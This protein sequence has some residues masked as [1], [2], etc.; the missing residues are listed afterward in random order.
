[1]LLGR[2]VERELF[3]QVVDDVRSGRSRA[4]VIRGEAGIGKTALL[5]E[6][7]GQCDRCSVVR[8]SGVQSEMELAY[9]ALHQVSAPFFNRRA[10]L[11]PPQREALETVFGLQPGAPPDQFLV[12]LA[13]L[14]LLSAAASDQPLVCLIDDAHWLDRASLQ[15]LAFVARR[16]AADSVAIVFA[17]RTPS[18]PPELDG[19]PVVELAG[20]SPRDAVALLGTVVPASI[21]PRARARVIAET[22]GNPLAILE[23]PQSRTPE[24]IAS[25]YLLATGNALAGELE[26]TFRE[27][28][29]DLPPDTRML[30]LVAAAEP[31]ADADV[32]ARAGRSLGI[33]P[34]A[35]AAAVRAGLCGP[36][37]GLQMRHPLVRSAVYRAAS[38]D[39][40]RRVHAALAEA[41]SARRSPIGRGTSCVPRARRSASP[42]RGQRRQN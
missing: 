19:L 9:A 4:L 6:F 36:A 40:L 18:S 24:E 22:R 17:V 2:S 11:P 12:A 20:L 33:H 32:V 14:S 29:R 31:F 5:D 7:V 42:A 28:L 26:S 35:S 1:M 16:L 38:A 27:R 21:H 13:A 30:L 37:P 10:E 23:L 41:T 34:E 39:D 8:V 25:G 15:A 3:R